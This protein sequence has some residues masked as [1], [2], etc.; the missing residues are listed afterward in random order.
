MLSRGYQT[1]LDTHERPTLIIF[2]RH[3]GYGALHK[4]D[5]RQAHGEPLSPEEVRLTEEFY[6]WDPD[7]QFYVPDGVAAHFKNQF[8][9]RGAAVR[10]AWEDK[11]TAYR[12]QYPDLADQIDH[13]WRRDLPEGWGIALPT[14]PADA[15]GMATQDSSGKVRN[16]IAA[17]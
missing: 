4:H 12:K 1:F 16:A 8:G 10:T 11:F 17:R 2:H 9:S 3:I 13:M 14:F 7:A 15:K 5:T 6:G